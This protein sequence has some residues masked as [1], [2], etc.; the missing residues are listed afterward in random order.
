MVIAEAS[1][2]FC[3][4]GRLARRRMRQKWLSRGTPLD[5]VARTHGATSSEIA[6]AGSAVMPPISGISKIMHFTEN[7]AAATIQLGNDEFAAGP[8]LRIGVRARD[9]PTARAHH[10]RAEGRHRHMIGS[11]MGAQHRARANG[12]RSLT[13]VPLPLGATVKRCHRRAGGRSS[14]MPARIPPGRTIGK[15]GGPP[16]SAHRRKDGPGALAGAPK[17][18]RATAGVLGV[19]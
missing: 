1:F 9:D 6:L 18:Q 12:V 4:G 2:P 7:V 8:E 14:C 13:L 16:G 10:A 5:P 15:R 11:A 17:P 3:R 19:V